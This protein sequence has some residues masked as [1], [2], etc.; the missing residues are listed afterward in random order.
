MTSCFSKSKSRYSSAASTATDLSLYE[1]HEILG[2][3]IR[4]HHLA[5]RVT[6]SRPSETVSAL[7]YEVYSKR[8]IQSALNSKNH[9]IS[10]EEVDVS[11]DSCTSDTGRGV[12][13]KDIGPVFTGVV[14]DVYCTEV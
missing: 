13:F 10:P 2:V 4:P 12:H 8:R 11:V 1:V 7:N 3:F 14:D 5:L 6:D 9:L